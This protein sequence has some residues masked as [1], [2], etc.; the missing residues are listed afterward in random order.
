MEKYNFINPRYINRETIY[1]DVFDLFYEVLLMSCKNELYS[2]QISEE[3][4]KLL[5]ILSGLNQEYIGYYNEG[6]LDFARLGSI[7][8]KAE[9]DIRN[10]LSLFDIVIPE[11]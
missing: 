5:S 10:F 6:E 11:D 4:D 3:A 9:K 7:D 2:D 1:E 8:L